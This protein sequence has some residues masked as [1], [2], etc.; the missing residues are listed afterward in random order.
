LTDDSKKDYGENKMK[1]VFLVSLMVAL[2]IGGYLA[3]STVDSTTPTVV[4]GKAYDATVYVAGHGGHFAKADVTIDPNNSDNPIKVNDLNMVNI[5]TTASHKTH[6]ARIDANDPNILFWSTYALDKDGKMH[7]G[8]SDLRTGEVIKDVAMDP[9]PRAPGKTGPL[10]CASGQSKNFYMPIFM[11]TEAYVDLLDKK[12]LDKKHR[13]FIS[14]IGYKAGTYQFVHGINSNDLKKFLI[15]V[16]MKGEDSKMNGKQD[17]I[18][19]DLPALEK[20]EWKV[21]SKTT[22]TGE[23][24]KTITFRGYFST[25]DKLI[26]QSAGDRMYVIDAATLKLVDEKMTKPGYGENHDIMPSPDGKY[27]LLT[28]RTAETQG[29]DIQGNPVMDKEGKPLIITDGALALYDVSAKKLIGKTVSVC[30][31]CHKGMGTGDKNAILCG[32]DATWKK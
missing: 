32:L 24:A 1:K 7:V 6:D 4:A 18:L 31:D 29:C 16:V 11:G 9:D 17:L 23:P 20:G 19:V 21:L 8:K 14:D 5:G 10:Y 25:D 26:F 3:F 28:L 13:M 2:I 30:F 22:L 15:V 12:T 27:A